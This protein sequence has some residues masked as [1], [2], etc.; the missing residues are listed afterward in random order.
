MTEVI[1]VWKR[2]APTFVTGSTEARDGDEVAPELPSALK[3]GSDT[4]FSFLTPF[5]TEVMSA[6]GN[7]GESTSILTTDE[8]GLADA[9]PEAGPL[10]PASMSSCVAAAVPGG[11][12]IPP[13]LRRFLPVLLELELRLLLALGAA[14]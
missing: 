6:D 11:V 12:R 7:V 5:S 10:A 1:Q 4:T 14:A 3:F 2:Q 8:P 9:A 13:A